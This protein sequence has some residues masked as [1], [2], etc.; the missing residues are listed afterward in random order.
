MNQFIQWV[1]QQAHSNL[2]HLIFI[3]FILILVKRFNRSSETNKCKLPPS[4]S[5][6]PIIGN[7]HQIHGSS[8]HAFKSLAQKHGPVMLLHLGSKPTLVVSS[9]EIALDVM[10]TY[11]H[12]F[13]SRPQLQFPTRLF[14]GKDIAFA[15]HGE[16]WREL[17]KVCVFELLNS[18][19]VQSFRFVREEEVTLMVDK[20][21]NSSVVN[22][23]EM[24]ISLSNDVICR[25][26]FGRKY[27]EGEAGKKFKDIMIEL[28]YL[29]NVFNVGDL[30]PS[31]AWVN[32]LNGLNSRV[33]KN[34]RDIDSFMEQVVEEHIE[35]KRR[36]SG[37]EEEDFVD[38]M[39]GV[40][41]GDNNIG[42]SWDRINTKAIIMDM[43]VAGTDTS[44]VVMEWAMSE[45]IRH[46]N[47]MQEV[48]KEGVCLASELSSPI[49]L[50]RREGY[51]LCNG[52][53]DS[54]LLNQLS[55][56]LVN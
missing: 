29:L 53:V 39:L 21:K 17:R 40:E 48:Q 16:Y 27:N 37:N 4:P 49:S 25:A 50:K 55:S 31:L 26:A 23:S 42:V 1:E 54:N 19:K 28:M 8:H 15:P 32:N 56:Q 41:K 24:F 6:L 9:P 35:K 45:L 46:P 47:V 13:A 3:F 7:L 30:I 36:L 14:Y 2:F 43:F 10:K 12:I 51:L 34:F 22:L 44:S 38:I 5:K 52:I 33:E 18:Q 20:I 11:D